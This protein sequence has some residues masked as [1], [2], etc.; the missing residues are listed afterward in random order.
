MRDDTPRITFNALPPRPRGLTDAEIGRVFG[1]C[2]GIGEACSGTKD[3]CL[4]ESNGHRVQPSCTYDAV[5]LKE[6]CLSNWPY[7]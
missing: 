5:Y 7:G 2:V 6:T 4:I 3:C 1:G